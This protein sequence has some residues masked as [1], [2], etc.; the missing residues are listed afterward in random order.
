M[1]SGRVEQWRRMVEAR[2][3]QGQRLDREHRRGDA[4]GAGRAARFRRNVAEGGTADPLVARVARLVD[5]ESTV[6]DVGGGTGRHALP[7][8]GMARRVVVVE[9]SAAM[10]EQLVANVADAGVTNLEVVEGEWPAAAERVEAADVV[11][12]AHVL[13]PVVE[14]EPFLRAL[15]ARSRRACFVQ[16]RIG[17]REGPYLELFERVWGEPRHLAPTAVDLFDVAHEL[18]FAAN[19]EVVPF[20]AWRRFDSV[21]EAVE[22]ARQ[23]IL[24]PEGK[25]DLIRQF[26]EPRLEPVEGKLAL[27]NETRQAGV[28]WWRT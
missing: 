19:F 3:E 7:L 15:D 20:P 16:L 4:W 27:P 13:Y 6:L 24:N 21:D 25:D 28:V 23:D 1:A 12:C 14:V 10:R 5:R 26:V 11:I 2:H 18:G 9:P 22:N 17:Q 8:A